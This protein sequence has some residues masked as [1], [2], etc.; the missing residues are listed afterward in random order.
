MSKNYYAIL[1]I[2]VNATV[3]QIKRAYRRL[4]KEFHPDYHGADG[5]DPFLAIQEAYSVLSDPRKKK[6]YDKSIAAGRKRSSRQASFPGTASG[7]TQAEPLRPGGFAEPLRPS[8]REALFPGRSPFDFPFDDFFGPSRRLREEIDPGSMVVVLTP[9]Q[10]AAGGRV[11]I[12]IPVREVCPVCRGRGGAGFHLC[13]HCGGRGERRGEREVVVNYPPGVK[14]NQLFRL[15]PDRPG[16]G[17][18]ALTLR[19]RIAD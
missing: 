12:G 19:F 16:L 18:L 7:R 5:N 8:S 10:A 6:E 15:A 9:S 17:D 1:G 3:S 13:L 14:D 11:R 2:P 4:V